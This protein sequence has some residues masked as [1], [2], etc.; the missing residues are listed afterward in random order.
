MSQ[1]FCCQAFNHTF[2]EHTCKSIQIPGHSIQLTAFQYWENNKQGAKRSCKNNE[3]ETIRHIEGDGK[4]R[5]RESSKNKQAAT[6]Q[7]E[8]KLEKISVCSNVQTLATQYVLPHTCMM[9]SVICTDSKK[10]T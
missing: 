4:W 5:E 9:L 1:D 6:G 7:Q 2:G 3:I 10:H 8:S